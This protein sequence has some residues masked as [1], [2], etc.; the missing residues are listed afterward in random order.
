MIFYSQKDSRW[1]DI[2]IGGT[3]YKVGSYGCLLTCWAMITGVKPSEIAYRNDVFNKDGLIVYPSKLA[4]YLGTEYINKR[5]EALYDPVICEV[6]FDGKQHFVVRY[7]GRIYDPLSWNGDP[8]RNY[9]IISYRNVKPKGGNMGKVLWKDVE[10]IFTDGQVREMSRDILQKERGATGNE[11]WG[12][13]QECEKYAREKYAQLEY[14]KNELIKGSQAKVGEIKTLKGKV[15]RVSGYYEKA[16]EGKTE[17]EKLL[18]LCKETKPVVC[19][20]TLETIVAWLISTYNKISNK[21][22]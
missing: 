10:V 1:K 7:N 20:S 5:T 21:K 16:L 15:D 12:F 14:D 19:K 6:K 22:G 3:P 18:K 2:N 9:S 17:A 8:L 11:S 4:G 13:I